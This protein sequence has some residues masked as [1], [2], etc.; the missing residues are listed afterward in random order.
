[1]GSAQASAASS[2]DTVYINSGPTST[3]LPLP[4]GTPDVATPL[5]TA[6]TN[7]CQLP[8]SGYNLAVLT[9]GQVLVCFQPFVGNETIVAGTPNVGVVL[10][11][12]SDP[13]CGVAVYTFSTSTGASTVVGIEPPGAPC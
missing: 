5:M 2:T 1:M 6:L 3:K 7:V 10:P 13:G 12:G 4:A 9:S 11:E 8:L